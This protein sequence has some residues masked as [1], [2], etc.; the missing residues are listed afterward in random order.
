VNGEFRKR[1]L[2]PA[3]IPFGAFVF[4]GA[5][6]FSFSRILLAVPKDGSVVVGVLMAGCILF[7]AGALAKGGNLKGAQRAGLLGFSLL[8]IGGGVAAAAALGVRPV[9]AHLQADVK[10]ATASQGTHYSFDTKELD[11][12]AGRVFGLEFDNKDGGTPHDV[13]ILSKPGGTTLFQGVV[14]PGPATKLEKADAIPAGVY[15]FQCDVHPGLMNGIVRAGGAKGP[16]PV[17]G[18][19]APGPSPSS[20]SPGG[21]SPSPQPSGTTVALVAKN[22]K[23]DLSALTFVANKPVVIDFD[24]EDRG[25]MHNFSLYTDSSLK[26]NLFR[27]ELI[28][29]VAHATFRFDAPGPG[30]YYFQCDVHGVAMSGKVTIQ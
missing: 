4:I 16:A 20:P 5:L 28:L 10:I 21:P 27:G 29:G 6:V 7:A 2:S 12:P 24:N 14:F 17:P 25:T 3:L 11:I 18:V 1:V 19:P 8:L 15:Y 22:T 26:T 23:F 30:T 9:E 13:H